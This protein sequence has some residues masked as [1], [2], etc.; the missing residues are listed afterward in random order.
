MR[1]SASDIETL[2][3]LGLYLADFRRA[4]GTRIGKFVVYR[5]VLSA[6]LQVCF[7]IDRARRMTVV[8]TCIRSTRH[9]H[10][11]QN[12][13]GLRMR[14]CDKRQIE[15]SRTCSLSWIALQVHRL[16]HA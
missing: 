5:S 2:D 4:L 16:V 12:H 14:R 11:I 6:R 7:H 8:N 15:L 13:N 1:Q 9:L 3:G 10:F